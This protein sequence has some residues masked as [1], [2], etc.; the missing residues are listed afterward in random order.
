MA[1][2][3][4]IHFSFWA[5]LSQRRNSAALAPPEPVAEPPPW[6]KTGRMLVPRGETLSRSPIRASN[7]HP[8]TF[9]GKRSVNQ[10]TR[11][12]ILQQQRTERP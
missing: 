3:E 7:Q 12:A 1:A 11:G 9:F 4:V 6:L 2:E 5:Q 10:E 8:E